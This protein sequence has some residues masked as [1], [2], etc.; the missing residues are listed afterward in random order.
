MLHAAQKLLEVAICF[1][2]L[3]P[4]RSQDQ[5]F[6]ISTGAVFH[7]FTIVVCIILEKIQNA[8]NVWVLKT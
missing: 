5:G 6:E 7:D 2:S 3:E 1:G 8:D 4:T